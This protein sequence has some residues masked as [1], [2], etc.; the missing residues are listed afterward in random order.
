MKDFGIWR[1]E[2]YWTDAETKKIV[3]GVTEF[4]YN[5]TKVVIV[6]ECAV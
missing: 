6:D 3:V 1:R 2:H 4:V 5:N